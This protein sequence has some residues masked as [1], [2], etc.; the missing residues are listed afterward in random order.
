MK[1]PMYMIESILEYPNQFSTNNAVKETLYYDGEE[2]AFGMYWELINMLEVGKERDIL[3]SGTHHVLL[4]KRS[5][6]F[7]DT[8]THVCGYKMLV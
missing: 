6:P 2:T 5:D 7:S 8:W 1:K 4:Y 3:V